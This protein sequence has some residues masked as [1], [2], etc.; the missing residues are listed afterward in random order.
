MVF[1]EYLIEIN[2]PQQRSRFP[3]RD[4]SMDALKPLVMHLPFLCGAMA[5][6][7]KSYGDLFRNMLI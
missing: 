4:F 2:N 6:Y 1:S 7:L 3:H 5:Q